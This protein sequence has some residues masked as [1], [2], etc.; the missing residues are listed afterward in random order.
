MVYTENGRSVGLVVDRILDIVE[1]SVSVKH[2]AQ[3]QGIVGAAIIQQQVTDLL[4]V[5][6]LIRSSVPSFME[7]S[8]AA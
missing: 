7:H 4:D 5:G 8:S 6:A 2:M 3:T 1:D